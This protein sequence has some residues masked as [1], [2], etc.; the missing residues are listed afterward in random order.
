MHCPW[1]LQLLRGATCALV[2]TADGAQSTLVVEAGAF[3]QLDAAIT[4]ATTGDFIRVDPGTYLPFTC[5]KGVTITA[6]PGGIVEILAPATIFAPELV[7]SQVPTGQTA[8]VRG[9]SF[10]SA[11]GLEVTRVLI[12]SG[13]VA[14]E[15]CRFLGTAGLNDTSTPDAATLRIE[16]A[17]VWLRDCV[18][19]GGTCIYDIP[20]IEAV[21]AQ[22]SAVDCV[23]TGPTLTVP[24]GYIAA[25][26]DIRSRSSSLHVVRYD[27]TGGRCVAFQPAG[28]GVEVLGDGRTWITDSTL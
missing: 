24:E 9:L 8:R 21:D 25:G 11:S 23:I 22:V 19:D 27:I 1:S 18:V 3:A 10:V 6:T 28:N 5:D 26:P 2:C 7:R 13:T 4:A 20:T 15:S 12:S 17:A 16:D 14:F